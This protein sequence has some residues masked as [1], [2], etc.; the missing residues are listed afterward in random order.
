MHWAAQKTSLRFVGVV[1][2]VVSAVVAV[3]S[4]V[5]K[6][7]SRMACNVA[8]SSSVLLLLLLVGRQEEMQVCSAGSTPSS[9]RGGR[10]LGWWLTPCK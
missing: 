1:P 4:T 6:R 9:S 2:V 3:R 10:R 7:G 5:R 8:M